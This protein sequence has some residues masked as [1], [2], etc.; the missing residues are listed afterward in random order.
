MYIR[1]S[2]HNKK[3]NMANNNCA[4]PGSDIEANVHTAKH[5]KVRNWIPKSGK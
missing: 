3:K 5:A 2:E 4:R 1:I